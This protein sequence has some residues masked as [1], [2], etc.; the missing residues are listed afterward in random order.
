MPRPMY[1]QPPSPPKR[2]R[3]S[4]PQ[5]RLTRSKTPVVSRPP[6][7][8]EHRKSIKNTNHLANTTRTKK[9]TLK[10]K[11]EKPLKK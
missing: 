11:K 10:P 4:T 3:S 9:R 2:P 7:V 5:P 8:L 1:S 6:S